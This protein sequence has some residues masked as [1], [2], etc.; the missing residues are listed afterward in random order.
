MSLDN[1][2]ES[3]PPI[4][5]FYLENMNIPEK[6]FPIKL[7]GIFDRVTIEDMRRNRLKED[8]IKILSDEKKF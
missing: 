7:F 5:F 8:I 4:E 6:Y 1:I 3:L 2:K